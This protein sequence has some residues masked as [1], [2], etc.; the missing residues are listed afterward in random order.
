MKVVNY[1]NVYK[2]FLILLIILPSRTIAFS[3]TLKSNLEKFKVDS[4]KI[5]GNEKTETYIILRELT[6]TEGDSVNNTILDFNKER[7]FS[8]GL[9]TKV[10]IYPVFNNDNSGVI[11]D[12]VESWYIYPIPFIRKY[13][14]SWDY[15]S[16]GMYF[17]YQNFQGKNENLRIAFGLGY[18]PFLSFYYDDPAIDYKR[19][20]GFTIGGAIIDLQNKSKNA[21]IIMGKK[22]SNKLYMLNSSISKRLDQFN[23]LF[24]QLS[25]NYVNAPNHL[26]YKGITAST[27]T[28][29]RVISISGGYIYDTRNLKQ[30][31]Q[32]GRFASVSI[33][34]NGFNINNINYYVLRGDYREYKHI[35]NNF[36]LT[37]WRIAFRH[38]FGSNV[39]YYNFSYLGYDEYV[40]GRSSEIREGNNMLISSLEFGS[41]IIDEFDFS[42]KLPIIPQQ[43]TSARISVFLTAF[44]D[45]GNAFNNDYKFN[46][47]DFY[48]GYGLGLTFLILPYDAIRLEY[49]IGSNG[50]GEILIATGFSF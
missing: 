29:D 36:L 21:E 35:I 15:L 20:L 43:L 5:F 28:I 34:H 19:G 38:T 44:A 23:Q 40:R 22:Y 13:H 24:L 1:F 25:F 47:N 16:V 30:F 2:L 10:N 8:L 12:V 33:M 6:F 4:I 3:D 17:T 9:F 46:I 45:A 39:P 11:I 48:S 50:K 42:L 27:K 26:N 37:R 32:D 49:A 14:N 7:V 41:P 31:S 18:D